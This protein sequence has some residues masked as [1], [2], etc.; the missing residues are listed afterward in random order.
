MEKMSIRNILDRAGSMKNDDD[1][2]VTL[3]RPPIEKLFHDLDLVRSD[4]ASAA[5]RMEQLRAEERRI[6]TQ[7]LTVMV[8]HHV[9]D[10]E[11]AETIMKRD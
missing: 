6:L 10:R 2:V 8:E 3:P 7:I 9:I 5:R 11:T 1:S 4:Q